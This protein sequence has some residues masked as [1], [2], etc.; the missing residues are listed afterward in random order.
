L[1]VGYL[2]PTILRSSGKSSLHSAVSVAMVLVV[3]LV[4]AFTVWLVIYLPLSS[5]AEKI[6]AT[7]AARMKWSAVLC[8]A[9]L[10]GV[11]AGVR[12][13]IGIPLWW[14]LVSAVVFGCGGAIYSFFRGRIV[15]ELS[16]RRQ[17]GS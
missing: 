11:A 13:R 14:L 8:T 1:T 12:G 6:G 10:F 9:A 3:S 5:V 7:A 2:F 17:R 4:L 16:V 15:H